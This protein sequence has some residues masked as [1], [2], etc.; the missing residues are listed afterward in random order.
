VAS[1][2]YVTLPEVDGV[3]NVRL[4]LT[5]PSTMLNGPPAEGRHPVVVFHHGVAA[6]GTAFPI[7]DRYE[8]LFDHWATRGY[9]TVS[10]DATRVYFRTSASSSI[11]NLSYA[12]LL[13]VHRFLQAEVA[14]LRAADTDPEEPLHGHLDLE[15]M[16]AS[17]HSRGGGGTMVALDQNPDFAGFMALQPVSPLLS[18]GGS[19]FN[20]TLPPRPLLLVSA[21]RDGDVVFPIVD[22]L[23]EQT[24]GPT[25]LVTIR[26]G[27]HTFSKRVPVT[28]MGSAAT[29]TQDQFI[30]LSQVYTVAFLDRYTRM[31]LSRESIVH[32]PRGQATTITSPP[33]N[34]VTLRTRRYTLETPVTDFQAPDAMTNTPL[35][36]VT[37]ERLLALSVE[38]PYSRWL[39]VLPAGVERTAGAALQRALH[40]RYV[41]RGGRVLFALGDTD[42]RPRRALVLSVTR[43]NSLAR[44]ATVRLRDT[45]GAEATVSLGAY[46]G[47]VGLT[48]RWV[49]SIVPLQA[50][51]DATPALDLEHIAE[52]AFLLD[53]GANPGDLWLD[54]LRFE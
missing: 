4:Y 48:S 13:R 6:V 16:I 49:S 42:L 9:V 51:R 37:N 26:G 17:G 40:A 27:K 3:A 22:N 35:G 5:Y 2:R 21:G 46:A 41:E 34:G 38:S 15:H 54:D 12:N 19:A 33:D 31:D 29:I 18:P 43:D 23:Y 7:F 11:L 50:F 14:W 32:G 8:A 24:T 52:L 36:A 30:A 28:E 39:N 45:R 25:S 44:D 53:D 47:H 1:H 10:I 20:H